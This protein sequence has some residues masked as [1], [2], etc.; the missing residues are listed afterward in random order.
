MDE[1]LHALPYLAGRLHSTETNKKSGAHHTRCLSTGYRLRVDS[2]AITRIPPHME[3]TTHA[4]S[5]GSNHQMVTR[6]ARLAG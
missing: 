2:I 1:V 5:T 4:I 6:I 3:V